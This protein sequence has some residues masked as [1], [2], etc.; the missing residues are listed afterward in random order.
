VNSSFNKVKR[1]ELHLQQ[2]I[3]WFAIGLGYTFGELG[4]TQLTIF[5]ENFSS[6]WN[7]QTD[8]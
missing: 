8:I 4:L 7:F 2:P 5:F 1:Y 6:D 3:A